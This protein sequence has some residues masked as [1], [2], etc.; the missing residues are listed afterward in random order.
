MAG[1]EKFYITCE[2]SNFGDPCVEGE[3]RGTASVAAISLGVLHRVLAVH[4]A[5]SAML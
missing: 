3:P 2:S 4:T 5:A 1:D